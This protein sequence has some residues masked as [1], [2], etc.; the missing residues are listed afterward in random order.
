[1]QSLS[2]FILNKGVTSKSILKY[3]YS[4]KLLESYSLITTDFD[5]YNRQLALDLCLEILSLVFEQ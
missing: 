2:F 3:I 4:Y 5:E 1:M